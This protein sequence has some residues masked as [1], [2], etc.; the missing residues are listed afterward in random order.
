MSWHYNQFSYLASI[1]TRSRGSKRVRVVAM[2]SKGRGKIEIRRIE[3]E[4]ARQVCFSKRRRGLFNKASEL[5][6]MCGA[7]VAIVVF[8]PGGKVFS[9]GNPSVESVLDRFSSSNSPEA[10]PL[11]ALGGGTGDRNKALA[12]LDRKLGEVRARQA[13]A[14]E[15]KEAVKEALAKARADGP[16]AAAWLDTYVMQ[17]GEEDLV[18]LAAA[19]EKVQAAMAAR[20]DQVL[21]QKLLTDFAVHGGGGRFEFGG[22]SG[23]M[24][25]MP[26]GFGPHDLP[27]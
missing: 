2:A 5:A 23:G 4:E 9:C 3:R 12:E 26:Q 27:Q 20:A 17:M 18:G 6:I 7:E 21:R 11:E 10:Q 8:S 14:K 19:L 13:A 25:R 1:K 24:E 22:T 15:R 16:Q